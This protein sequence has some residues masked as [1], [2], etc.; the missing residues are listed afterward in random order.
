MAK[1]WFFPLSAVDQARI[2]SGSV[3]VAD[4]YLHDTH[5]LQM[6]FVI[7]DPQNGAPQ[8]RPSWPG[9]IDFQPDPGYPGSAPIP[10]DVDDALSAYPA[11]RTTGTLGCGIS[12]SHVAGLK[13]AAG[14]L[15]VLPNRAWLFPIR[16]TPQCLTG[17]FGEPALG[18]SMIDLN[19]NRLHRDSAAYTATA[20]AAF[21]RGR[22]AIDL[23]DPTAVSM[24]TVVMTSAG[25]VRLFL[26]LAQTR[27]SYQDGSVRDVDSL[28]GELSRSDPAHP[29]NGT[30]APS[31]VL[32]RLSAELDGARAS[33]GTLLPL[34]REVLEPGDG[35]PPLVPVRFRRTWKKVP[36][37]SR[38]F[39][40]QRATVHDATSGILLFSGRIPHHGVIYFRG[41][42]DESHIRLSVS[43]GMRWMKGDDDTQPLYRINAGS[44][45]IQYSFGAAGPYPEVILRRP[46]SEEIFEEP[47]ER[48]KGAACTY[49]SMRRTIRALANNRI[50]GGML[51]FPPAADKS[52]EL[53]QQALG[54]AAVRIRGDRPD[55]VI[56]PKKAD[57]SAKTAAEIRAEIGALAATLKP[58][59]E[60]FFAN[61]GKAYSLWQSAAAEWY[62]ADDLTLKPSHADIGDLRGRGAPGALVYLG[63][64]SALHFDPPRLADTSHAPANVDAYA[65]QMTQ[66]VLAGLRPGALLQ[67]WQR[68]EG[69]EILKVRRGTDAE[70]ASTTLFS[71]HSPIFKEYL[72]EGSDVSGVRVLDQ[73]RANGVEVDLQGNGRLS[74]HGVAPELWIAANWVE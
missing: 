32:R 13:T 34:A 7:S 59:W 30:I 3:A 73:T 12:R 25:E 39:P 20:L 17:W 42:T 61:G 68:H 54:S 45:E 65:A 48:T 60:A 11:W 24:P 23:Q 69:F 49:H 58:V 2:L 27:T 64:A 9:R 74:W 1:A 10:S 72:R 52:F 19:R 21:L 55:Q 67:F 47:A 6:D 40:A 71:G 33:D 53:L 4:Q 26:A 51:H 15:E 29:V 46:M 50:A 8:I 36:N 43:G 28:A 16:L 31:R 44:D 22:H 41:S 37:N 14:D 35:V 5:V 18:S 62:L 57:G 66:A 63:L 70:R 38:H 56:Q